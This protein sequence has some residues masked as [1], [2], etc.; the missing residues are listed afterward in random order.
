MKPYPPYQPPDGV[1]GEKKRARHRLTKQVYDDILEHWNCP[2]EGS[3]HITRGKEALDHLYK[4]QPRD[5]VKLIVGL[6]P[7]EI[8]L[9]DASLEDLDDGAIS[10]MLTHLRQQVLTPPPEVN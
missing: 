7:K 9:S 3:N 5:Y 1:K 2:V 6:L 8:S 4:R 10:A